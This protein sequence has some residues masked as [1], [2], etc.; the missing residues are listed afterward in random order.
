MSRDLTSLVSQLDLDEKAALVAGADLW[1]T[2][3]VERLGIPSVRVTDGPNG[4][5]GP[6]L[7]GAGG[8]S[9]TTSCVPCGAALGAT[10]NTELIERVGVLVGEEA[11]T[12]TCRVLLA[13]TVNLHRS[14]LGGR[15]FESYSEDPLLAGRIGAAFIRGAQ[16]AGVA[17]TVKHF[18]GNE[19]ENDR[20]VADSIIGARAL[21]EN[22]LLPFEIAITEGGALG[23]MTAYNRLNGEYCANSRWLLEDVLRGEWG[24]D[25]FVISDWFAFAQTEDAVTA[26]LDLEM[27]GPGRAYGPSLAEAVRDGRVDVSLVD[28]AVLRLLTAFDR[29][30]AF[31]DDPTVRPGSEDRPGHRAVAREAA[32]DATVLLTNR[33]VLPLDP[34]ALRR[35]AVI[36]P[37]AARAVIMGGGS[38]QVPAHYLRSP[39]EALRDRL[40]PGVEVVHEPAVDIASTSPEVPTSW[41]SAGG[42]PGM[43]VEFFG[44]DDF[45]GEVVHTAVSDTGAVVWFGAPPRE[46]GETFAWRASADLTVEEAG[47]WTVSLVQT[48]PARLLVDGAVVLDGTSEPAGPGRDLFGLAKHEITCVLQL[49]PDRPVRVEMQSA[50]LGPALVTGAKLGLR[51]APGAGGIDRAVSAARAADATIVVV[52]TDEHWESEGADRVSMRLPGAQD[53]LVERVLAVAPDAVV[54]LNVGAPVAVPWA[55][56][57]GA[58]VQCWFGGQEM[59]EGLTDVLLGAADPGG[60]LPTTIPVRLEDSPSWGNASAEGG[61]THYGEGILVGYRWYESRGID[62]SF[63]FGHGMSYTTF[64]IGRPELSSSTMEPGGAIDIRIPVTNTGTRTGSEVVQIYVAPGDP[65][66]FRPPKELKGFA[67]TTLAPGESAV[68]EVRLD[69]RAFARWAAPD[70]ALVGLVEQL[71]RT[72]FW[73]RLPDRVHEQG[74]IIDP[75]PYELHIGRSSVDIARVVP[76]QVPIG[77]PAGP[78]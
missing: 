40:G 57:A 66:A 29:V 15:N 7:P 74:W 41:L 64:E 30:G 17:C 36:G 24:F 31:D 34:Q 14:P 27:P 47:E 5:R 39:L 62:V 10:W 72:A 19:S 1:S 28:A 61:R 52:G 65:R 37:N 26:G 60:R 32:V 21:R 73:T 55:D 48:D 25:G 54:V 46:A 16:S 4:A 69:D 33:G 49:S 11:R 68:L 38:A 71:A 3:A 23:I 2:V 35:V 6:M 20:M 56:R 77:G 78:R 9:S 18:A 22:H 67:K 45:G 42:T 12:K 58:V 76:V 8:E 53:E 44:P 59:A 50:V 70:P 51:P 75:G 13:P 63:P 43:A